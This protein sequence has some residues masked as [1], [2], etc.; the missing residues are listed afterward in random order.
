MAAGADVAA[1]LPN[2]KTAAE[3]ARVNKKMK[4][5]EALEA[6]VAKLQLS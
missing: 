3:I 2:G 4:V 5:V 6:G 1:E